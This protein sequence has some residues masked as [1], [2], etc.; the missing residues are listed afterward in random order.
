MGWGNCV[1]L[2][3]IV[4][5]SEENE[6]D[7]QNDAIIEDSIDLAQSLDCDLAQSLIKFN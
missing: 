3:V 5:N 1:T 2:D 7:E 6:E 4:E